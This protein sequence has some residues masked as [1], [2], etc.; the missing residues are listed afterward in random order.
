MPASLND[1]TYS[2]FLIYQEL[3][4]IG[5]PFVAYNNKDI[6]ALRSGIKNPYFNFLLIKNESTSYW[7]EAINFFDCPFECTFER[8]NHFFIERCESLGL[9]FGENSAGMELHLETFHFQ[10]ST[11]NNISI[12]QVKNEVDIRQWI[13]IT[14]LGFRLSKSHIKDFFYPIFKSHNKKFKFSICFF[15]QIPSAASVFF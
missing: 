6:W 9:T 10:S 11:D 3:A 15:N 13:N 2:S 12:Q 5:H 1:F 14:A 8:D 4:K 7:S